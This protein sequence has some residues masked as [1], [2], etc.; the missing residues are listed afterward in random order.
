MDL[1][2]F[3]AKSVYSFSEYR[4][5]KIVRPNRRTN[6]QVENIAVGQSTVARHKNTNK[7]FWLEH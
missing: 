7:K 6:G 4:V 2:H 5:N 3:T 1:C